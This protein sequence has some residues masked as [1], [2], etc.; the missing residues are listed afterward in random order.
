MD[1]GEGIRKAIAKINGAS[2][3][4]EVAVNEM[5]KE[6]QRSLILSDVEIELVSKL[7]SNIKKQALEAKI[8]AGISNRELII[9]I[10]YDQ[11]VLMMGENYSPQLNSQKIMLVGLFGAGKTTTCAKLAK[12]YSSKGLKPGVIAADVHRPAAYEQLE[13]LSKSINV[14][15]FGIKGETDASKVVEK[16]LEHLHKN[17]CQVIILDTAGRS[18]FDVELAEELKVMSR[19]YAP[20]QTYLVISADIG[21]VAGKQ[22]RQFNSNVKIDGV[23]VTKMDGS[24]KGGGALS[25]V[26]AVGGK[27][28]FIGSGEKPDALEVFDSKKFVA[29][30]CGF[31]DLPAL[32]EKLKDSAQEEALMKAAEIGKLDYESFMGQLKSLKKMGP[33]KGVLQMMGAYDLPADVVGKSEERLKKFE[34]A[35]NSMTIYER[36]NPQAMKNISRQAR[37]AKGAGLDPQTVKELVSNFEKANK[38]MKGFSSN[39]GLLRRMAKGFPQLGSGFGGF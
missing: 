8:Q 3:I 6:I 13:Q 31:A 7:T 18:A 17:N 5:I 23:I 20:D 9:K 16:G 1:L 38:M 12:F 29:R 33:L 22:A 39:K 24:G 10:V 19:I 4:D 32:L 34:A 14:D 27:V 15:F 25:A 26:N 11:L 21:Q 35:V 36:R 2:V 37:V 28:C 30:L